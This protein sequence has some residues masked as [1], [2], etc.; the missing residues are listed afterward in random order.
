MTAATL[1]RSALRPERWATFTVFLVLGIAIG[2]WAAAIPVLK[3]RLGLSAGDLSIVLLT[4]ALASVF[5]TVATG[6]LAPRFGT[7][8]STGFAAGAVVVAFALPIFAGSFLQLTVCAAIIGLTVGALDIAMNAHASDIERRWRDPIMSSFHA[9]FS[10][11]GLIGASLGG[12]LAGAPWG[13]TGQI[14]LPMLVALVAIVLATPRL[15][16]GL[17]SE[18]GQGV[19]LALPEWSALP[20]CAIALLCFLLEGA[21]ADWSAVYL[22]S[23]AGATA[24]VSASG[25]AGFS[26]TMA[27]GRLFGDGV[28][29]RLG[30]R[31]TVF[32]GGALA[33]IGLA[34]ALVLPQPL[35]GA[36]GFALVGLG[37][38][39][40][41]P[42]AFSGA[43]RYGASPAA[44]MAMVAT[45]G[46]AGF[47]G[48]PPLIGLIATATSLKVA[49]AVVLLAPLLTMM[50]AMCIADD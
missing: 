27:V 2:T 38:S 6:A 19:A 3:Q 24:S 18:A 26:V 23:V 10:V 33:A 44:G 43:S 49:L 46:Y 20:L 12:L 11:G 39:N 45:C 36:V 1:E 5:A 21:M 50:A 35:W 7:G 32:S 22:E 40:A 48:G 47:L 4:L 29:R 15:G 30:P 13:I 28:V 16:H 34:L 8:R 31:L 42:V 41:V 25:Y 14:A 17:R 9:A 37:A